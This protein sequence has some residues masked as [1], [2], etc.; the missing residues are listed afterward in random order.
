MVLLLRSLKSLLVLR[1]VPYHWDTGSS[2]SSVCVHACVFSRLKNSMQSQFCKLFPGIIGSFWLQMQQLVFERLNNQDLGTCYRAECRH[3]HVSGSHNIHDSRDTAGSQL[4]LPSQQ[5]LNS[6]LK[7]IT[8]F[9][10]IA[11]NSRGQTMRIVRGDPHHSAVF[12]K[13]SRGLTMSTKLLKQI[14]IF[15]L[16]ISEKETGIKNKNE[17]H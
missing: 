10:F 16:P 17:R 8:S 3:A 2:H 14:W 4:C 15:I 6:S 7:A 13:P 9:I 12:H 5:R 1:V 11:K